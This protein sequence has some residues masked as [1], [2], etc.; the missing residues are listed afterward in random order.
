M[1][2]K[3]SKEYYKK[4]NFLIVLTDQQRF[5]SIAAAGNPH[6]DTP[7]MDRLVNEGCLFPNAYSPNP[8]CI[9]A[10]HCLIT[11]MTP[12]YH[13]FHDNDG[14]SI[15]DNGIPTI[16]RIFSENGWHT[17]AIGKSHFVPPTNH[18]GYDDL[19]SRQTQ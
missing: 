18:H 17:A 14:S 12:K 19:L 1:K 8:I 4:T 15:K 11:G 2:N 5:D 16:G 3:N 6:M 7:N 10:R 9:P 13:G